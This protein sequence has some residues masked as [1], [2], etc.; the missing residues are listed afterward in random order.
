MIGVPLVKEFQV[1]RSARNHNED[2]QIG[3]FI[4]QERDEGYIEAETFYATATATATATTSHTQED[5]KQA[6]R[7]NKRHSCSD[8]TLPSSSSSPPG[9]DSDMD[10]GPTRP[11]DRLIR[12]IP[13]LIIEISPPPP[14][15]LFGPLKDENNIQ[16]RIRGTTAADGDEGGAITL[17]KGQED[18][19]KK[20][21]GTE[22][23]QAA[24]TL[25]NETKLLLSTRK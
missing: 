20:K 16:K 15:L 25:T 19:G 1:R 17:S 2:F 9:S 8:D 11:W 23:D 7:K 12:N 13:Q 21:K 3:S 18:G 22:P 24:P 4:P 10:I 14:H 5:D 6:F